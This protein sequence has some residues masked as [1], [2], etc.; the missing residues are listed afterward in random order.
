MKGRMALVVLAVLAASAITLPQTLT[1]FAGQHYWYDLT[2]ESTGWGSDVPCEKCH[3]DI[4]AEMD[5]HL[6]P[7][8]GETGEGRMNCADCHRVRFDTYQFASVGDSYTDYTPGK[9]AHAATT[10]ACMDCHK[11]VNDV[12]FNTFVFG[13]SHWD[14]LS[15][16]GQCHGSPF[17]VVPAAGGFGLTNGTGDSGILAA[18]T[19]FVQKSVNDT[20]LR[21]ENEACIGCHTAIAVK[22]NWTHARVLEFEVGLGETITTDYGPHNWTFTE[23]SI[24]G[25]AYAT[26]WGNTTGYGMTSYNESW[27]GNVD[28]IYQ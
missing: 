3:A 19:A 5:A 22:L 9:Y 15:E 6:G 16:C 25:T 18:H 11:W 21:D 24:N 13:S 17:E 7:H 20:T 28:N 27:P 23:W 12:E 8:T 26:T 1:L 4:K 14:G 2:G 10:V